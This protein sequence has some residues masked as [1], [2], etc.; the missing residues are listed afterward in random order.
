MCPRGNRLPPK[1]LANVQT[2][3]LSRKKRK[4]IY[5]YF[6]IFERALTSLACFSESWDRVG[7]LFA[8]LPTITESDLPVSHEN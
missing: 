3:Y 5:I 7:Y 1:N 8:H 6:C 4:K 2:V